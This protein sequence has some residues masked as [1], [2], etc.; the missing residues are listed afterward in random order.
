MVR[1]YVA[2]SLADVVAVREVQSAVEVAGHQVHHDWTRGLDASLED[3]AEDPDT[4]GQVARTDLLAVLEADALVL[5]ANG[6]P[7]RGMFVELGAALACVERGREMHVVVVGS[8]T[9]DS[10]FYFHP[11]VQRHATVAGWLASV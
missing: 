9:T 10:V 5:V 2:G 4:S 3:Y 11:A 1:V 8:R 6:Q 7:G